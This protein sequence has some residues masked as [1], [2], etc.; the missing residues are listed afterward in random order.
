[1]P[2]DLLNF[3]A[4]PLRSKSTFA[5]MRGLTRL[6]DLRLA[7]A[8]KKK[9]AVAKPKAEKP[10]KKAKTEKPAKKAKAEKAEK[11]AKKKKAKKDPN[12]PK[13]ALS[14]FMFFSNDQ[15]PKVNSL[16]LLKFVL[17]VDALCQ[18]WDYS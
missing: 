2:F 4:D 15:R 11:P 5:Y 17:Y 14:A 16:N 1:M 18:A 13:R 6:W 12:A 10:A 3:F 8:P 7:Q 9:K